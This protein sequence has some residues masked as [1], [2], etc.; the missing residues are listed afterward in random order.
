MRLSP[1]P[2]TAAPKSWASQAHFPNSK[3]AAQLASS[4]LRQRLDVL[5][6]SS[7]TG[8]VVEMEAWRSWCRGSGWWRP[9]GRCTR[10]SPT[11]P[12]SGLRPARPDS[13]RRPGPSAP[14]SRRWSSSR[15]CRC[16]SV[17]PMIPPGPV[18]SVAMAW[19]VSSMLGWAA[20]AGPSEA[21]FAF[22][23][24]QVS[25]LHQVDGPGPGV[26]PDA[27]LVLAPGS[28][29]PGGPRGAVPGRRSSR[30]G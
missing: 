2:Y 18:R 19:A 3:G 29:S 25:G 4:G 5:G 20:P 30:L 12:L 7:R 22:T 13:G 10:S 1:G 23:K 27:V 28:R 11:S 14:R 6:S 17:M 21:K 24:L 26:R 8:E 16:R 15:W 9:T